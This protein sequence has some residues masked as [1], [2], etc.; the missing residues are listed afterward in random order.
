MSNV[1]M[2]TYC[3]SDF[4][5]KAVGSIVVSCVVSIYFKSSGKF[6]TKTMFGSFVGGLIYI[7]CVC[8]C[9]VVSNTYC[10]VLCFCFVF[11]RLVYPMLPHKNPFVVIAIR[12]FHHSC[13]ITLFVTIV[14]RR[15][16]HV[17]QELPTL[18]QHLSS[19]PVS[20]GFM[21]LGLLFAV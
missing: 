2:F 4:H 21:L 11:L 7:I 13:I 10:V 12:F 18:P 20:V 15:L 9:I 14:T 3:L 19:H 1:Q 17:M 5:T 8:L 6:L 16:P